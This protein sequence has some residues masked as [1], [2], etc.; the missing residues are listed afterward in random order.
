MF[1]H[2]DYYLPS[3]LVYNTTINDWTHIALVYQ[4]KT[5]K[6]YVNGVLVRTGL[7]SQQAHVYAPKS[8]GDA[9]GYGLYYGCLDEVALY[10]RALTGTEI[11]SIF[12]AGG[13]ARCATVQK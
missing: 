9:Y 4:N 5:P 11:G 10:N 3:T 8:L 2:G 6:L 12:S 7:T 1:E 13:E